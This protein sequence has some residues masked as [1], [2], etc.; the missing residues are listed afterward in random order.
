MHALYEARRYAK[1][2]ETFTFDNKSRAVDKRG[3]EKFRGGTPV[4]PRRGPSLTP[5]R[6]PSPATHT[7]SAR[8]T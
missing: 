5:I 7:H 3:E 1:S 2:L 4:N 6:A 8:S